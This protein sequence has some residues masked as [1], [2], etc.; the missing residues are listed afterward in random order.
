M[1]SPCGAA[2]S[3]TQLVGELDQFKGLLKAPARDTPFAKGRQ[4]QISSR[5]RQ[6]R[7]WFL[8][9]YEPSVDQPAEPKRMSASASATATVRPAR[10]R[11]D[12]PR[13]LGQDQKPRS[14]ELAT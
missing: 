8:T 4:A 1:D 5:I 9:T 3:G 13:R 11:R 7:E 12:R 14:S 2:S 6:I 10:C